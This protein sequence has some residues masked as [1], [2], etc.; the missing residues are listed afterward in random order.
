VRGA[1]GD[2]DLVADVALTT[3][4]VLGDR[5]Q[6]AGVAGQKAPLGRRVPI[7]I[8]TLSYPVPIF[9]V[10]SSRITYREASCTTS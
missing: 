10:C 4:G 6:R 3:T 9:V 7:I 1:F 5:E 8:T 2:P